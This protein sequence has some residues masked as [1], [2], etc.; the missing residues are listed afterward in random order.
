M[1]EGVLPSVKCSN[2]IMDSFAARGNMQEAVDVLAATV[3]AGV[4]P[5]SGTIAALVGGCQRANCFE[6]AFQVCAIP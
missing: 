6:L 4:V 2:R 5:E 3:A 1:Q